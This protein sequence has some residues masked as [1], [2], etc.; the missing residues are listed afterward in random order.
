MNNP[1]TL[2]QDIQALVALGHTLERATE[3][4]VADR[5]RNAGKMICHLWFVYYKE[6]Y[7]IYFCFCS[8]SS[9]FLYEWNDSLDEF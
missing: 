9:K 1:T 2:A 4:A 7:S 3:L 5:N 8:F 6:F